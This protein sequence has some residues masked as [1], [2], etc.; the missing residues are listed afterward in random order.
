MTAFKNTVTEARVLDVMSRLKDAH[1]HGLAPSR[2]LAQDAR[3]CLAYLHAACRDW[4]AGPVGRAVAEALDPHAALSQF[5]AEEG[6]DP[7]KET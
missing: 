4:P 2:D 3:E 5:F 6:R 7:S 1:D